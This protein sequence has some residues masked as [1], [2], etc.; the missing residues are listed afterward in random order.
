MSEPEKAL[1][2]LDWRSD[3]DLP[4]DERRRHYRTGKC[5][6]RTASSSGLASPQPLEQRGKWATQYQVT[7][8]ITCVPNCPIFNTFVE[9]VGNRGGENRGA[10][11]PLRRGGASNPHVRLP[12]LTHA[13]RLR[14]FAFFS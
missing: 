10:G 14:R 8:L 2:H 1:G 5:M 13:S 11:A 7:R 3:S 9:Q 6:E 4:Q 12:V